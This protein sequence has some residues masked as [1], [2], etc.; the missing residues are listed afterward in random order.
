MALF[1]GKFFKKINKGLTSV[2]KTHVNVAKTGLAAAFPGAGQYMASQEANEANARLQEQANQ[3]NIN[4]WNTQ[5]AYNS[6]AE[7]MKRLEAAGLNPNLAYGQV[8]ESKMASAPTM[9]APEM[10]PADFGSNGVLDVLNNYQ[11]V[12]NMQELNKKTRADRKATELEND[13]RDFEYTK[14]KDRGQTRYDATFLKELL[15]IPGLIGQLMNGLND[16][17]RGWE[18]QN[19]ERYDYLRERNKDK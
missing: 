1:G 12:M 13:M 16:R 15:A 17:A 8:A 14:L 9:Q 6:P 2:W 10:R 4:L 7:Q 18:M 19:R 11:Q 5:T 3:Q